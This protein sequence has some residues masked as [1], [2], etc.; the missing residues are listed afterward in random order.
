[1]HAGQGGVEIRSHEVRP[2]V[3]QLRADEDRQQR[4]ERAHKQRENNIRPA[5]AFCVRA[6]E[7]LFGVMD[8]GFARLFSQRREITVFGFSRHTVRLF[9]S[10]ST[11]ENITAIRRN[12]DCLECSAIICWLLHESW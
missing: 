5:D 2:R 4:S 12:N 3:E 11:S 8:C 10:S 1:M 7:P 6:A 9:V